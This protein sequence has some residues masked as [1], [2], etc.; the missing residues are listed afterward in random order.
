MMKL[1]GLW[2]GALVFFSGTASGWRIASK[3]RQGAWGAKAIA[4]GT[5]AALL[6]A[7][8]L[9]G[10]QEATILPAL[11]AD[12]AAAT[13]SVDKS[14]PKVPLYTKTSAD[15][16]PYTDVG[17][18]FK[19]LRPFGFN[20]FEG[21]GSGYLVKFASLF[22]VDENVVVGSVPATAGKTSITQYGDLQ[23]LGEKL[24][25]KRGGNL[26][27][28]KARE[29]DGIVFYTYTFDSPLDLSLPRPGSKSLKPTR[30]VELYQLCVNK[31]RLWSVQATSNDK[32]FPDHQRYLQPAVD[33]FL[34][35]L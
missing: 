31:G 19:M 9:V 7:S 29:T 16:M 18:G 27:S 13:E 35:R 6:G 32:V 15:T 30:L 10:Y 5:A 12:E 25:A 2:I 11:A 33:S 3:S 26:V 24:A 34:P 23:A 8:L 28:A 17:R 20:E 21:A 14:I 1:F 4:K 22:D